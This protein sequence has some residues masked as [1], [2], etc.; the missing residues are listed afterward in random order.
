M[1]TW[2]ARFPL[3]VAGIAALA[4]TG[5]GGSSADP[6]TL[7]AEATAAL[8]QTES[9]RF[10]LTS[11][12][13]PEGATA[14]LSGEGDVARPD[15]FAGELE[16]TLVGAS[17]SVG[18]ISVDGVLYAQLPFTAGYEQTDPSL[19]GI[20]DPGTF[21]AADGGVNQLLASA[22]GAE[23]A[24]RERQG[25]I[26]VE[27]VAVELPPEVVDA[28]LVAAE[29]AGPFQAVLGIEPDS[30]QLRSAEITGEFLAP[31]A[32]STYTIE[33]SNY[34]EPVEISAPTG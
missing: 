31:G 26:V 2:P 29:G 24:G 12:G 1:P 3:A 19:L 32:V 13:V 18:V 15:R 11:E 5:C 25:D 8:E 34:N 23:S 20:T 21:L 14:L 27:Q 22:T 28:V 10:T 6:E 16:V 7:L 17:T 4:L 33:L 30:G 9:A